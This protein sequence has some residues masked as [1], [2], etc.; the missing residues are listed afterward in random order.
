MD[1]LQTSD[2]VNFIPE[3][4]E[5]I[6]FDIIDA[7]LRDKPF[8]NIHVQ[9]QIDDICT[10]ITKELVNMNKPFK[11]IGMK[12]FMIRINKFLLFSLDLRMCIY[13]CL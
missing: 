1:D 4:V 5:P 7:A 3:T 12:L 9:Q 13:A 8:S 10:R 6:C 11:Y 2:E